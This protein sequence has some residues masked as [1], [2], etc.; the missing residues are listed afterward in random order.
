MKKQFYH[1]IFHIPEKVKLKKKDHLFEISGPLGETFLNLP[2]IDPQGLGGIRFHPEKKQLELC[3]SSKSF[4]GLFKKLLEN[5]I[6][7]VTQ[8]FLISIKMSGIGYR[9]SLISDNLLLKVGSSHDVLYKIPSSVKLFLL[10]PT[11]LC[12]FGLDK[13]QVTQLAAKIRDLRPPSVYKGKGIRLVNEKIVLKQ[14]KKNS[15]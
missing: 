1:E 10:D 12:L 3:S 8:G 15:R 11:L 13:N 2:K 4:F 14:G 6:K 9:A 5:K 7:G